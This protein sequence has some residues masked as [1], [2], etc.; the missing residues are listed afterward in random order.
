MGARAGGGSP[1]AACV[2]IR[3]GVSRTFLSVPLSDA[4]RL[5]KATLLPGLKADV[6][7]GEQRDMLMDVFTAFDQSVGGP[8]VAGLVWGC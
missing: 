6:Y 4:R 7:E 8:R 5:R 3:P 1:G 2:F